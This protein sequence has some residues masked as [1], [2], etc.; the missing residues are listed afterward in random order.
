M[1]SRLLWPRMLLA[2]ALTVVAAACTQTGQSSGQLGAQ[3]TPDGVATDPTQPQWGSNLSLNY[4]QAQN[5]TRRLSRA[6][7]IPDL[8][9]RALSFWT[10]RLTEVTNS[11]SLRG[12]VRD[13]IFQAGDFRQTLRQ[14]GADAMAR[15]ILRAFD[16]D[17]DRRKV[18]RVSRRLNTGDADDV[19]SDVILDFLRRS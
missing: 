16:G 8:D 7:L 6:V 2:V 18:A 4:R 9:G 10:Q 1:N 3:A 17:D 14:V 12:W 13:F 15:N 19:I 11:V 5:V